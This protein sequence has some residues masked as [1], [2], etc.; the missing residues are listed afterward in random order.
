MASDTA[1]TPTGSP[2]SP[3]VSS[4]A[5]SGSEDDIDEFDGK[6]VVPANSIKVT[7]AAE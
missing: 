6:T 2:N 4:S 5:E 3:V 7:A 1:V